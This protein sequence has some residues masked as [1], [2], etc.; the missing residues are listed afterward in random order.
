MSLKCQT[1]VRKALRLEA[2][3]QQHLIP[4]RVLNQR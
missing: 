3:R 4:T 2:D 1:R